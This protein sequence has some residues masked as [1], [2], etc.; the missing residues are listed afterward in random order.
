MQFDLAWT[1]VMG[2]CRGESMKIA[3]N[4]ISVLLLTVVAQAEPKELPDSPTG[5][6]YALPFSWEDWALTVCGAKTEVD[7]FLATIENQEIVAVALENRRV[8]QKLA[9]QEDV[10]QFLMDFTEQKKSE[11]PEI[12][13]I[14]QQA[15]GQTVYA[16]EHFPKDASEEK[17]CMN[18]RDQAIAVDVLVTGCN[19]FIK[20]PLE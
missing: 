8:V 5:E 17:V 19:E 6:P 14:L 7:E 15:C 13:K 2:N 10:F 4:L 11:N 1:G 16:S 18:D 9:A 20:L 12:Q 3:L